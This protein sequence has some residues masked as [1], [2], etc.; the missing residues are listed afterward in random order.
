MTERALLR[1]GSVAAIAG[2]VLGAI[3][4]ALHPRDDQFADTSAHLQEIADSTVWV[5]VHLGIVVAILLLVGGL[6]ALSRSITEG[7]GAAFARLGFA[8]AL[9]GTAITVVL[10]GGTDGIAMKVV[11]D[12][13]A[14]SRDPALFQAA[15]VLE[16]VNF[17]LLSMF[18]FIL[19]GLTF[20]LYGLAVSLTDAYPKWLGWAGLVV[21]AAG[22]LLGLV[23]AYNGPSILVTI[24]LFPITATL[25]TAWMVAMGVLMWRKAGAAPYQSH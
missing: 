3:G 25:L 13:W 15:F 18:I 8:S 17:G 9:V 14:S 10:V 6:A 22:S 19:F 23:Q 1:T 4:T 7:W 11:A 12:A 21:G 5:G 2:A 16:Q 24:V 20:T